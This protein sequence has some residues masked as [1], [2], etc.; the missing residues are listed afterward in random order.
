[1]L[2]FLGLSFIVPY[3]TLSPAQLARR[4]VIEAINVPGF[5]LCSTL[6]GFGAI[7]RE[8]GFDIWM[9]TTTTLL[10]FGMPGQVA[11][12]SLYAGGAS[13][14][15]IFIAVS[16]ANLRMMLMVISGSDLLNLPQHNLPFWKRI[17]LM[18]AMAITGWAQIGFK[19]DIIAPND[20]LHYYKGFASAIYV[21]AMSGTIIGFYLENLIPDHVLRIVIFVTPLYLL[22]LIINAKQTTNKLAVVIGGT[23]CPLLYP[24]AGDWAILYAGFIGGTLSAFIVRYA[25]IRIDKESS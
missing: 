11:M 15:L 18:Q 10:V 1:M 19:Q 6:I 2:R 14:L 12:A 16:L 7:A 8:A 20:L 24:L 22:L 23:S 13:L 21:F 17:L 9:T 4:G 3:L 5:A 25:S